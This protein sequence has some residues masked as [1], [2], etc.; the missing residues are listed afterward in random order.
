LSPLETDIEKTKAEIEASIDFCNAA[1]KSWLR[2]QNEFISLVEKR[3]L[4][5]TSLTELTRK[6]L[7]MQEKKM[8]LESEITGKV[9]S[10]FFEFFIASKSVKFVLQFIKKIKNVISVRSI[11][12]FWVLGLLLF[13]QIAITVKPAVPVRPQI[14]C[15]KSISK[16]KFTEYFV[17][18]FFFTFSMKWNVQLW[19]FGSL[20]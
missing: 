5:N 19:G 12:K 20:F 2:Y 17:I 15:G 11:Y 8:K 16:K 14:G 6:F 13:V 4:S 18:F 3:T 10:I 9:R 7:I 1:K